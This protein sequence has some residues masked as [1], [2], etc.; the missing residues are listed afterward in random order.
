MDRP[1]WYS[2]VEPSRPG[3]F[4]PFSSWTLTARFI[5]LLA[6]VQV[7]QLVAEGKIL[8]WLALQSADRRNPLLWFHYLSYA[9]VHA[10]DPWHLIWNALAFWFFGREIELHLGRRSYV[11][12]GVLGAVGGSVAFHGVEVLRGAGESVLVGASGILTAILVLYAMLW[13]QRTVMLFFIPVRAWVLVSLFIGID[14]YNGARQ[15][16]QGGGGSVA[17]FAH[18]GGAIVGFVYAR[19]GD[20]ISGGLERMT[21]R[22]KERRM[23]E[24]SQ[25]AADERQELDRILDKISREGM[26]S[27]TKSERRFLEST[28]KHLRNRR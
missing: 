2:D 9:L 18:V 4:P 16:L 7:A 20:R 22:I 27:L 23:A 11:L 17:H 14:V 21:S 19:Y 13:P 28:S 26:P 5:A 15:L 6:V 1:Q 24:R 8:D 3:G 12:L 10:N 25:A